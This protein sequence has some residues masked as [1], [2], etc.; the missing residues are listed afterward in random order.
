MKCIVALTDLRYFTAGRC[1]PVLDWV[2]GINDDAGVLTSDND[3]A[4]HYLS[5]SFLRQHFAFAD[6]ETT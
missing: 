5:A 3:N 2:A 4:E 6:Q 1:Y